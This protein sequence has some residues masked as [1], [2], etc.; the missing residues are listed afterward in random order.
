MYLSLK[1]L[2]I[3]V[4][5]MEEV[6][7]TLKGAVN[8]ENAQAVVEILRSFTKSKRFELA[9]RFLSAKDKVVISELFDLL[10]GLDI[11]VAELKKTFGSV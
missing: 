8:V 11:D 9:L 10:L 3:P 5:F 1:I 2:D 6:V 4:N 7:G